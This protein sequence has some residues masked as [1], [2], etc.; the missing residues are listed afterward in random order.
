M[1]TEGLRVSACQFAAGLGDLPQSFA[2]LYR[3]LARTTACACLSEHWGHRGACSDRVVRA[4]RDK[5]AAVLR[6]QAMRGQLH[7]NQFSGALR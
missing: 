5:S 6:Q 1:P 2:D 4:V 3:L 7:N